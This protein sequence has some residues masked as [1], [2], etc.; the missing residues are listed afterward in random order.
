[1]ELQQMR[2]KYLWSVAG[3]AVLC[4]QLAGAAQQRTAPGTKVQLKGIVT[5]TMCGAKQH[6]MANPDSECVR[7]CVKGGSH[8]ALLV[9]QTIYQL[10]GQDQALY[11]AAGKAVVVAG[12][13]AEPDRILVQSVQLLSP[14]SSHKSDQGQIMRTH[15]PSGDANGVSGTIAGYVRD[16]A[17]LLRNAHAGAATSPL[18]EDCLRKCVRDGSPI[19]I[20]AD[21]GE[22][23][24]PISDLIPDRSA[25]AQMMPYVGKYV[26]ISGRLFERGGLHGV[27]IEKIETIDRPPDSKIP[28]L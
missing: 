4:Y 13:T 15:H 5:D 9:G 3:I 23:F 19:G 17:C 14:E 10:T 6:T 27:S 11:E 16:L 25:R 1:M 7:M 2:N 20:L 28:A 8:Y 22:I 21:N 26:K 12:T 18:T 24:L